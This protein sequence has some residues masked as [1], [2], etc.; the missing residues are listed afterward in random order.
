MSTALRQIRNLVDMGLVRRWSD[1]D[2]RRR[3]LLEIED[4]AMEAMR[5][6]LAYVQDRMAA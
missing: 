1:P 6:Y 5:R 3:D 4:G 2:D